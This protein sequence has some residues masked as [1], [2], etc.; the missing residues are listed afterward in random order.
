MCCVLNSLMHSMRCASARRGMMGLCWRLGMLCVCVCIVRVTL[1]AF[2]ET[3]LQ[4]CDNNGSTNSIIQYKLALV[5]WLAA[6]TAYNFLS[7]CN[8]LRYILLGTHSFYYYTRSVHMCGCILQAISHLLC[9]DRW[10]SRGVAHPDFYTAHTHT[11]NV[12]YLS[13]WSNCVENC[14]EQ[15]ALRGWGAA[16][17]GTPYVMHVL[18]AA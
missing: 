12:L 4:R 13:L 9:R 2:R 16:I 7:K 3:L 15:E 10:E 18:A 17:Y 14:G 8:R 6:K 5:R 11:P 1:R